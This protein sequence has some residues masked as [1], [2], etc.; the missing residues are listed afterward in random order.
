MTPS[1]VIRRIAINICLWT[2]PIFLLG[3]GITIQNGT[4]VQ[5]S[6]ATYLV[7]QDGKFVNNGTFL[8][9][10]STVK[11]VGSAQLSST[12][13]AGTTT[14]SFYN[15][16][17]GKSG[18]G[19]LLNSDISIINRLV[20]TSG[21]SLFL[22]GHNITLS[23]TGLVVGETEGL[24]ITGLNGGYISI[25]KTLS[26]P[27]NENPGNLGLS[28][29][30]AAN[31]GTISVKR[32]NRQKGGVSINRYYEVIP[33]NNSGLNAS[34][35]MSYFDHELGSINEANLAFFTNSTPSSV[36]MLKGVTS[37][38]AVANTVSMTGFASLDNIT[39]ADLNLNSFLPVRLLSFTGKLN[40][41]Q[42]NLEWTTI[43]EDNNDHFVVERSREGK[44]F[45]SLMAIPAKNG[46]GVKK[47][48]A[49]DVI[50]YYPINFYRLKQFDKDGKFSFSEIVSV[51]T[52]SKVEFG[53]RVFPNPVQERINITLEFPDISRHNIK[54]VDY[55]GNIAF[56]NT[57]MSCVGRNSLSYAV[58]SL[59]PGLYYIVID[60]ESKKAISFTK[61]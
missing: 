12:T 58:G 29:T 55:G 16:E 3:Q 4:Q 10:S 47:Y 13:I 43:A 28:I 17:L 21:D 26:S 7:I 14:S 19:M 45:S 42:V 23:S 38:N 31:L 46:I 6:G 15:V 59:T 37:S 34:L 2:S 30:S 56:S 60:R 22:N 35:I 54:I 8:P 20:L 27:S 9:N 50:P 52:D 32:Y 1:D 49:V 44:L 40:N 33:T 36:W 39:L 24:R 61:Q 57:F 5:S 51:S 25:T 41:G 53:I 11:F 48:S 18:G